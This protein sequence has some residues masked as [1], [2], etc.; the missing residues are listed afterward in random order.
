MLNFLCTKGCRLPVQKWHL[1]LLF[2]EALFYPA[3]CLF[4]YP[5]C[6]SHWLSAWEGKKSCSV[7]LGISEKCCLAFVPC[8]YS[9]FS[10][11][12]RATNANNQRGMACARP[13]LQSWT[14][15]SPFDLARNVFDT[16]VRNKRLSGCPHAACLTSC[17]CFSDWPTFTLTLEQ[18]KVLKKKCAVLAFHI[19]T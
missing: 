15:L 17:L 10:S 11:C 3:D 1:Q 18:G 4:S 6:F 13:L 16:K 12:L 2:A 5:T 14:F 7:I 19:W 8:I 9:V